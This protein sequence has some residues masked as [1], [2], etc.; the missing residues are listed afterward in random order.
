VLRFGRRTA[1]FDIADATV[2]LLVSAITGV[3]SNIAAEAPVD[4][5]EIDVAGGGR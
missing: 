3:Y 5:T 4:V 2:E 1:T